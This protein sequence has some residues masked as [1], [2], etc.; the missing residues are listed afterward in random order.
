MIGHLRSQLFCRDSD[1][2]KPIGQW[3]SLWDPEVHLRFSGVHAEHG[4][5]PVQMNLSESLVIY[6]SLISESMELLLLVC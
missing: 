6:A 1:R 2:M 4:A 3:L 5:I